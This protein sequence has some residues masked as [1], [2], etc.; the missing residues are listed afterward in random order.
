MKKTARALGRT[1]RILTVPI[2]SYALSRLWVQLFSGAAAALVTPLVESLKDSMLARPNYLGTSGIDCDTA[3]RNAI[4]EMQASRDVAKKSENES[5]HYEHGR[6]DNAGKR[7]EYERIQPGDASEP[8]AQ[9]QTSR[10]S[11]GTAH[12]PARRQNRGLGQPPLRDLALR[13]SPDRF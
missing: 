10:R 12:S 8:P 6:Y 4:Q 7:A 3:L 1:L 2:N 9:T 5:T 11:L 13:W